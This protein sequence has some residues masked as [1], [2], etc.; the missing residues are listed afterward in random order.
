MLIMLELVLLLF[1]DVVT[2]VN[3]TNQEMGIFC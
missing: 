2:R 1:S 3:V